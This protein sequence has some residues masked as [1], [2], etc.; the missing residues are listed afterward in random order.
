MPRFALL[1]FHA[2]S[3]KAL[4]I[5]LL[6]HVIVARARHLADEIYSLLAASSV[7]VH[8]TIGECVYPSF[9]VDVRVELNY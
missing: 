1:Y 2:T 9:D 5:D 8:R 7:F 3:L 6:I 4:V